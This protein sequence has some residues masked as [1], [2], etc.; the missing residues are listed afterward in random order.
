[1]VRPGAPVSGRGDQGG[2]GRDRSARLRKTGSAVLDPPW[3][4]PMTFTSVISRGRPLSCPGTGR[5]PCSPRIGNDHAGPHFRGRVLFFCRGHG[6]CLTWPLGS[7][8]ARCCFRQSFL[9]EP[10]VVLRGPLA[11]GGLARGKSAAGQIRYFRAAIGEKD[12]PGISQ[13]RWF[14]AGRGICRGRCSGG[15]ENRALG[16]GR[17]LVS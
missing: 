3:P 7:G 16:T 17:P 13:I 6:R 15:P 8:C 4:M 9:P 10:S 2:K 14:R 1:V 11:F 5:P 12:L